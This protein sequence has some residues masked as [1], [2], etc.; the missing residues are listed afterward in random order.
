MTLQS[1]RRSPAARRWFGVL[2]LL[3]FAFKALVPEGYMVAKVDGRARLV[4]GPAGLY[5]SAAVHHAGGMHDMA[6]MQHAPGDAATAGVNHA[7]HA[8][9][10]AGQCPYAL[11]GG[12]ALAMQI[13]SPAAPYYAVVQP[14]RVGAGI[15]VPVAPPLRHR[16]P[17]GPPALA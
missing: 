3:A 7:G 10:A 8:V 4:M 6:G 15:T 2:V 14:A 16:A 13:S 1:M 9:L 12:A 11:A 17:R 5:H